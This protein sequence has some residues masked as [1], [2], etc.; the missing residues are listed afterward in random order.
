[1]KRFWNS[2][3]PHPRDA[4][5][6]KRATHL[7]VDLWADK[8]GDLHGSFEVGGG[9]GMFGEDEYGDDEAKF[10]RQQTEALRFIRGLLAEFERK[11]GDDGLNV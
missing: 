9:F 3:P 11:R 2:P 5:I 4:E 6:I 1:M 7:K 8:D 10:G